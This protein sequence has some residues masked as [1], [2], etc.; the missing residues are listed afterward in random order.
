MEDTFRKQG[1]S[2]YHPIDADP[3]EDFWLCE[4]PEGT[5]PNTSQYAYGSFDQRRV[6]QRVSL[7]FHI[8]LVI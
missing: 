3:G 1:V 5:Q 4:P 7:S 8:Y 2:L 6:Q